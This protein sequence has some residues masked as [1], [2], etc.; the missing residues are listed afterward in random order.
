MCADAVDFKRQQIDLRKIV[1]IPEGNKGQLSPAVQ[2]AAW[3]GGRGIGYMNPDNLTS[4]SQSGK[5]GQTQL[6]GTR[7]TNPGGVQNGTTK[8][9]A[10]DTGG[11]EVDPADPT[12]SIHTGGGGGSGTYP[13]DG[14]NG[15]IDSTTLREVQQ[16]ENGIGEIT[17][18]ADG[19]G[20]L[21]GITGIHDCENPEIEFEIRTDGQEVPPPGWDDPNTPPETQEWRRFTQGTRW[22]GSSGTP[23]TRAPLAITAAES[24]RDLSGDGAFTDLEGE[25]VKD[26]SFPHTGGNTRWIF[27]FKNPNTSATAQYYSMDETCTPSSGSSSCPID[28]PPQKWDPDG[29]MQMKLVNGKYVV[30]EHEPDA[31]IVAKYK[32]EPRSIIDFCFGDGR[33][34]RL[35]PTGDMGYMIYETSGGSPTGIIKVFGSNNRVIGYTDAAGMSMF[36]PE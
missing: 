22:I 36:L 5:S 34:G 13:M 23:S 21:N 30:S 26:D 17:S 6:G 25:P 27:T 28:A 1:G 29:K 16:M 9:D 31:D 12:K 19:G 8:K 15:I 7:G 33:H 20:T 2:R 32:N 14:E 18:P 24:Q 35:E 4:G 11:N 10:K 3:G